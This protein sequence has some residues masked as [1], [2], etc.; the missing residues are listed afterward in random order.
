MTTKKK[1]SQIAVFLDRD[2]VI[3]VDRPDYVKSWS[4]FQFQPRVFQALRILKRNRLPVIVITNQSAVNRGLMTLDTLLEIHEK[5]TREIKKNG[6]QIEAIYYCPHTP[7]ENCECR[8]PKPG[9]VLR[10]VKDLKVDLTKSY[11][12]GDSD[13]DV[14]LARSL[15]LKC[16]RISPGSFYASC[17]EKSHWTAEHPLIARDLREAVNY[18]LRNVVRT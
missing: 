17:G 9:L 18:I 2:G 5:M 1:L 13:K 11:F 15:G 6:G 7:S 14:V 12:I 8:K 4:E 10:A 3:N 16:I